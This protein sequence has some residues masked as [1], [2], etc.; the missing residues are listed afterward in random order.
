MSR[1]E[2]RADKS[3]GAPS[4]P[5]QVDLSPMRAVRALA[6]SRELMLFVLIVALALVMSAIYPK[7]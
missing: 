3:S 5:G 2:A 4:R 6:N 1:L 7:K